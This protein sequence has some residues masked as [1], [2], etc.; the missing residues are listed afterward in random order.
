MRL[1]WLVPAA[2]IP[3][4]LLLFFATPL[5]SQRLPPTATP[6]HYDLSF[7]VDIARQR[8]D[9]TETIRVRIDQPTSRIVLHAADLEFQ[10]VTISAGGTTQ[11]AAVSLDSR[12]ETAT[13]TVEAPLA[14]GPAE[15]HIRYSGVLN[16]QLRGFY[17][18]NANGRRYAVTQFESTDARRAFPC[19]DEPA[20]KATFALT[21]TIDRGDIAISN[22]RVVSD[23]PGPGPDQHTV[24][25]ST[26]PKMSS[27]LVAMA[28]GDF[29]C[30][31]GEA[32][33]TPIRVCTTPGKKHLGNIALESAREILAY[34]N[35]YY[36]IKYPFGKL[37]MVAVPDFAAS[38]MENTAAIFYLESALLADPATASVAARKEIAATIAHE[39]AHQWFGNLVTMRW[40]DDLW[41]NEGFAT[42]METRPLVASKPDWNIPVDEARANQEAV[43][44]DSVRAT[45]PIH[46]PVQTPAEIENLFDAISYNKGAAV[47]RMIEHYVGAASFRDGINAYLRTHAYGNATSEDF[48][49]A[50]AATSGKPVDRVLPSF[51]NEPGVP[52]VQVSPLT[53]TT[54]GQTR[55]TFSQ[56]RF[57][58]AENTSRTTTAW[59]VPACI[60][61]GAADASACVVLP[62]APVT[63][64]VA[65]GCV[66]WIFANEGAQGYYRTEY[67]PEILRALAPRLAD[68]LTA[69][70]R[71]LLIDDEWALVRADRHNAADYLTLA[72]GYGRESS[73]GVL[74]EVNRRLNF[75]HEY[76][77]P[78]AS[79]P[80]F[81][82]FIR[83]TFRPL[84]DQLGF[85]PAPSETDD[86]RA[87]R[88]LVIGAL[89]S[90]GNDGDV[91]RQ[92]R[93]TVDRALSTGAAAGS[94]GRA[95]SASTL[96]P[97]LARA[98]LR[99][100]AEHGNGRLYDGLVAAA[101]RAGSSDE[102]QLYLLATTAFR[103]PS[104]VDRALERTFSS[105]VHSQDTARYLASFLDNSVARPR[106]WSFIKSNWATL[107]PR[108]RLFNG[109][110][111]LAES[112]ASFCDSAAR[113]D[114]RA[115]FQT[116]RAQGLAG[117]V[118]RSIE[119]VNNCIEM[120]E[121]QTKPVSDWLA[122][123]R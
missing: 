17:I 103:D 84:L 7:V 13:L 65:Q 60:K 110:S 32:E 68:V 6:E 121:K 89:G 74:T 40:W 42:W 19:F 3:F 86:R 56:E 59:Q 106:A 35:D 51:I 99:V 58:L 22:G 112:L 30:L 78:D 27:Y 55:V 34:L 48:W 98:V 41:L 117:G 81:E 87:L 71:L 38:A 88:A 33:G 8:F 54:D 85:S 70:E 90:I 63:L 102:R 12:A 114:I 31:E 14:V 67:A 97:A 94:A 57:L 53:C 80:R 76:L 62:P 39:M 72:A 29:E 45:R 23:T 16:S 21:L 10:E 5:S 49:R 79:R 108:L 120:R 109:R 95:A 107:E 77:T 37:D 66:P 83:T 11:S 4:L 24:K 115:F 122:S 43:S 20:F 123:R 26:S 93:A 111:T 50:I 100:A 9:G 28:V 69:P 73:S 118:N 64:N 92:A 119:Q 75:V 46:T 96:D 1:R 101:A 25:F 2:L 91:V 116:N 15:I 47:L 44:L 82:A 61:A 105:D 36:T 18:G 104:I 113:D 52:V